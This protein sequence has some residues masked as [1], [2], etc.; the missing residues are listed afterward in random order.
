MIDL[1]NTKY[2]NLKIKSVAYFNKED[3]EKID[4]YG[5]A[6]ENNKFIACGDSNKLDML[7]GV[8]LNIVEPNKLKF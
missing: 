3:V 4:W 6:I 5:Y 7:I 2:E 8:F 1:T